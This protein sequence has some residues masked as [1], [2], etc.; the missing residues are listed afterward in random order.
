[1]PGL[2]QHGQTS[3]IADTRAPCNKQRPTVSHCFPASISATHRAVLV[4]RVGLALYDSSAVREAKQQQHT[5]NQHA[6]HCDTEGRVRQ[7]RWNLTAD[8]T[9]SII[10]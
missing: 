1:M 2:H 6:L 4:A 5:Q 3:A 10:S 8:F 7:L 9:L